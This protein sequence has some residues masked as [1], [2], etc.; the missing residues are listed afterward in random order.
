LWHGALV[1]LAWSLDD[2]ATGRIAKD[3]RKATIAPV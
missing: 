1:V 3:P 2:G